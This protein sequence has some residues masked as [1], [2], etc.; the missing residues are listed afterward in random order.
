MWNWDNL[1]QITMSWLGLS[2]QDCLVEKDPSNST[3]STFQWNSNWYEDQQSLKDC[4]CLM[5]TVPIW[6]LTHWSYVSLALTHDFKIWIPNTHQARNRNFGRARTACVRHD[7]DEIKNNL[8]YWNQLKLLMI[9]I[10]FLMNFRH[11][12]TCKVPEILWK[13]W[14]FVCLTWNL[15]KN[16]KFSFK[17]MSEITIHTL[18]KP[19][20]DPV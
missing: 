14:K 20:P 5:T 9:D 3:L 17:K 6:W 8:K 13:T 10:K 18:A 19:L 1:F 12:V 2:K 11:F 4:I 16:F 15:V 7:S